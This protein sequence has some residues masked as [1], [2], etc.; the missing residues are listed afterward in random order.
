MANE[1]S[2]PLQERTF[3]Y[4]DSLPPLPVLSLEGSL[5]KYLDAGEP[6]ETVFYRPVCTLHSKSG[7]ANRVPTGTW[8][9]AG[10]TW[11]TSQ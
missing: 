11:V 5:S 9:P 3:Q 10:T 8:S 1:L 2:D 4:Q 7:I 6:V